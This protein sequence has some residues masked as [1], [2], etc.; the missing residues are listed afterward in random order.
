MLPP[1]SLLTYS[2]WLTK[3]PRFPGPYEPEPPSS[4]SGDQLP[5]AHKAVGPRESTL[6][7]RH[8]RTPLRCPRA[9]ARFPRKPTPLMRR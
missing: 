7:S 6:T 5:Q 3:W 2:M 9:G 8:N 1:I 4:G